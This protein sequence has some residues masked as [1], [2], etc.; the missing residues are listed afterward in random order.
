MASS[1]SELGS[2]SGQAATSPLPVNL[3]HIE[4]LDIQSR[5]HS[6]RCGG[7]FFDAV[8]IGSRVVFLLMDI[9]GRRPE[10]HTIAVDVQNVFRTRAQ[11]LFEHSGAN[12]SEGIATLAR[13]INCSLI[14]AASRVRFTAA[15]LGC[16]NL[17][18]HIL[19][20]HYAG[21]LFAAFRDA[22]KTL[23]LETGGIPLGLFTHSTYE[24]SVLAFDPDA[25]LLLVT[26]GNAESRRGPAV[27]DD[28][29]MRLLLE[30][31]TTEAAS[32]IC[33]AVMRAADGSGKHP[34]SRVRHF[35]P[36]RNRKHCEDLTAVALVRC[37][38]TQAEA[39]NADPSMLS[40]EHDI[41]VV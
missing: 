2:P 30:N 14:E 26:K 34:S 13:D 11:E 18:L 1:L 8:A 19:T 32:G 40:A 29:Q 5:Y 38:D 25:K 41:A 3:P 28:E 33:E 21:H 10:T 39:A 37:G 27:S 31:C 15:F 36:S 17:T 16:Y 4:G 22:E 20:Y 23:V 24:P 9:A 7:D 35:L 12:E 6:A